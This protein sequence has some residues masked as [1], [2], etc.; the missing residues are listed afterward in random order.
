MPRGYTDRHDP[1]YTTETG[2]LFL[3]DV[4]C[5]VDDFCDRA[6]TKLM[7]LGHHEVITAVEPL[8]VG[9]YADRVTTVRADSDLI[10]VMDRRLSKAGALMKIADFY[11]VPIPHGL[12]LRHSP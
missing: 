9:R 2:R 5:P 7:F 6:I 1:Q 3:P 10:Q 4:I 12:A 11:G 8:I